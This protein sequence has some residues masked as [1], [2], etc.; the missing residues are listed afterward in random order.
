V[1]FPRE[2]R[3]LTPLLNQFGLLECCGIPAV[4]HATISVNDLWTLMAI[5]RAKAQL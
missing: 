5:F 4:D 1:E 2:I 3:G